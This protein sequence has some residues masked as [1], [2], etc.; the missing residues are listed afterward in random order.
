MSES[1]EKE[2]AR[3]IRDEKQPIVKCPSC[4]MHVPRDMAIEY[5]GKFHCC[6]ECAEGKS[7]E[8]Q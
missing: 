8:C 2:L 4:G 6:V 5:Q 1:D 7:H 3:D